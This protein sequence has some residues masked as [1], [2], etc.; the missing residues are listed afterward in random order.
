MT[1]LITVKD[2]CMEFNGTTVLKKINFEVAEGETV[3]II[4]RSGAGKTVLMHLMRGVDQPP[5]QGVIIY[6]I[7]ACEGCDYVGTPRERGKPCPACGGELK[8]ADIDFWAEENAPM[9]R[10]IMR[11]TAIMFQR[12]FA[13]YGDDRVIENVL[14]A[15]DDIGYPSEKAISRAA[16]L[17]DQVRLSHRMMHIARDLSGGEKQRVVLARQLAKNPFILFADEPTGTLD[18]ETATLVHRMLIESAQANNMAM[19]VTSHFSHVIEEVADRAILLENGEIV[20]IGDPESVIKRFMENYSDIEQHRAAV[21]GEKILVARDV[22]KRYLSIDRGVV[23]AVNGVSFEVYEKEIFG[24]IGKSGAGKTTLSRIIAGI[25]EPT[26]GEMNIRIGDEWID[27]T[28]PGIENRG[29]AKT[30][31]GLLHQEYDLYPHRTVLDNLTDA[32]GLEFPKELAMGKAVITLGMAGFTPEKSRE[33]L[34][35]YPGQL[36]EGEKHR[37]ALA[38]VL[39]RE[40]RLVVLDEPTGTMDPITKL[41]VKH[42]ILH[43]REEMDETFIVV[44]HDIDFV[45]DICDRVALMR[46]GKIIQMGPTEEVLAH[47]TE[48]ERKVMGG[49]ETT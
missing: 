15:L 31:I 41:D 33:I 12:T 8:P 14:R 48:D 6:H 26:S 34:D 47:L 2:L 45:R 11:R 42:S 5:T 30:Y 23:R 38:Q 37:V 18:P 17:I 21:V 39:I 29:R 19:V 13:L 16:D 9:K 24:I 20:E 43:S 35:R 10:R 3:G 25:L 22:V 46:G 27:M 49:V 7:A 4:G 32:I 44:S 1:P 28:K 40:P 36:S